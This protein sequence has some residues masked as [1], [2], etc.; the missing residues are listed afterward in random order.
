[1][2][3]YKSIVFGRFPLIVELSHFTQSIVGIIAKCQTFIF[4]QYNHV[5]YRSYQAQNFHFNEIKYY[6]VRKRKIIF[7]GDV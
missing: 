6:S 1:M 2:F 4:E 7:G 5:K 3:K